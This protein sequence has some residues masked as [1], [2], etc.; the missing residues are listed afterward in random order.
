MLDD[1]LKLLLVPTGSKYVIIHQPEKAVNCKSLLTFAALMHITYTQKLHATLT[2]LPPSLCMLWPTFIQLSST[3]RVTKQEILH[4]VRFIF[5]I[6]PWLCSL[7]LGSTQQYELVFF[8]LLAE[9]TW[10][11]LPL[12]LSFPDQLSLSDHTHSVLSVQVCATKTLD[13]PAAQ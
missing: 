12:W 3:T 7:S 5:I 10:S 6:I 8:S 1:K 13:L 2:L 11:Q 4:R 9:S